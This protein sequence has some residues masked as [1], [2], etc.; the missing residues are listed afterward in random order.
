MVTPYMMPRC[1][2]ITV[3]LGGGGR[4]RWLPRRRFYM[5]DHDPVPDF[6]WA[7]Y[8]DLTVDFTLKCGFR[9]GNGPKMS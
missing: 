5:H 6:Q 2:V 1:D 3:S 8:N 9:N 7:D 4:L